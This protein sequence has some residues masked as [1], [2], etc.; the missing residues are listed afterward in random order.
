LSRSSSSSTTP[1]GS[2]PKVTAAD[3][4]LGN[5]NAPV[6]I[7]EYGDYKC[8]FCAAWA[9]QTEPQLKRAFI[10]TGKPDL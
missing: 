2:A 7:V 10:D 8:R 5:P 3:P 9:V 4:V 1:A 6:T